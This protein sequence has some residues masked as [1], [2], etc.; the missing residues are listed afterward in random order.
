MAGSVTSLVSGGCGSP[1]R[2]QNADKKR[3]GVVGD[4]L[5]A[6][7]PALGHLIV[8]AHG[9]VRRAPQVAG[10]DGSVSGCCAVSG[11]MGRMDLKSE[12]SP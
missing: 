9:L 12:S 7:L 6:T 8:A 10:K 2:V 3:S 11:A 4:G 1:D 5:A